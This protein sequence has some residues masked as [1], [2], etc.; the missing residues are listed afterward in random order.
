MMGAIA[1]LSFSPL[2][3]GDTSVATA[4]QAERERITSFSPLREGDTSVAPSTEADR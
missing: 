3:E 1:P 2:R 4:R